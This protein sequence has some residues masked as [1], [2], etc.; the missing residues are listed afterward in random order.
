MDRTRSVVIGDI[1]LFVRE[2]G[3]DTAVSPPLLVVH[4]GP[5]WDHTYLLPGLDRVALRRRV[6]ALDLR[7]CGRSSCALEPDGYQ[8]E[9][10]VE[11]IARLIQA[12]GHDRV[13]LLGFSTGGQVA[14]LFVEAHP[15]LL[16]RLIL[17][18]TTAYA[19]VE[20]YLYGWQE[21]TDRLDVKTPWPAWAPF[22]RGDGTN[23]NHGTIEWAIDS[24]PTAIW[25]IDRLD[26]YLNLLRQVR[27]TGNWMAPYLEGRLHPWRPTDPARVLREFGR[28]TL[29]LHGAQDMGFPVQV[30]ERLHEAVPGTTLAVIDHAGHMAHFDQPATWADTV[31]KFLDA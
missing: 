8:P 17:A 25:N 11:D 22:D 21:Y 5:D 13:D 12:L 20:H 16:R 9:F 31:I 1:S 29:I 27:F 26:E 2:M 30:A 15:D 28:D 3:P 18:S 19:D 7:G 6:I 14:Q 10:L 23:A 4:G 24:A